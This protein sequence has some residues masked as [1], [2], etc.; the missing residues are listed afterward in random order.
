MKRRQTLNTISGLTAWEQNYLNPTAH[1]ATQTRSSRGEET[2]LRSASEYRLPALSRE[3]RGGRNHPTERFTQRGHCARWYDLWHRAFERQPT[4]PWRQWRSLY[5]R[6]RSSRQNRGYRAGDLDADCPRH[7]GRQ[8][9][10][11]R[12]TC[13]VAATTRT[14]PTTAGKLWR[15]RQRFHARCCQ[16]YRRLRQFMKESRASSQRLVLECQSIDAAMLEFSTAATRA[17]II[18][19]RLF[20]FTQQLHSSRSRSIGR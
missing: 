16:G 7:R 15:G 2:D 19:A 8:S 3:N 12:K 4:A 18:S 6:Q 1:G 9:P 11:L 20:A 13:P 10:H 14:R 5:H 17:G